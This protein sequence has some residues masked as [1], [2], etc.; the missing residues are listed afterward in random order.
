[1]AKKAEIVTTFGFG[2]DGRKCKNDSETITGNYLPVEVTE[3]FRPLPKPSGKIPDGPIKN[4][5]ERFAYDKRLQPYRIPI[6]RV[7]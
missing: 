7:P 2:P 1:M 4:A 6:G 3:R 5:A